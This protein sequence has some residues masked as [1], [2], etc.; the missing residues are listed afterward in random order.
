[1]RDG[2]FAMGVSPSSLGVTFRL[3]LFKTVR[4][5]RWCHKVRIETIER[6]ARA[7]AQ[8]DEKTD[9]LIAVIDS[10]VDALRARTAQTPANRHATMRQV[11]FILFPPRSRRMRS[12]AGRCSKAL[13]T[14]RRMGFSPSSSRFVGQ[15]PSDWLIATTA[16]VN[17][18]S[19]E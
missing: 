12:R 19:G 18:S 17:V 5:Q 4:A 8:L 3:Q 2:R 10:V 1:M 13:S 14:R 7:Q 9:S 15:A 6:N 16:T 11:G